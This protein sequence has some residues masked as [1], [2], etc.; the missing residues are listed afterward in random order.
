MAVSYVL[1]ATK[2]SLCDSAEIGLEATANVCWEN[3]RAS[4]IVT[5]RAQGRGDDP[6]ILAS[7]VVR[8][9]GAA[10]S[11]DERKIE[12]LSIAQGSASKIDLEYRVPNPNGTQVKIVPG[13]QDGGSVILC[14]KRELVTFIGA[15]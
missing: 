14:P 3:N 4:F 9:I 10:Q 5:N 1:D 8:F 6:I 11:I 15:C 2:E 7:L 13:V 12:G